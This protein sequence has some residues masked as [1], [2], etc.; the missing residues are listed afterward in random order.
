[1]LMDITFICCVRVHGKKRLKKWPRF[2]QSS[3]SEIML[4]RQ[5]RPFLQ[6]A[7][8]LSPCSKVCILSVSPRA[9]ITGPIPQ[10]GKVGSDSPTPR[11]PWIGHQEC[12]C[13]T[14]NSKQ[15]HSNSMPEHLGQ[16]VE[17]NVQMIRTVHVKI[18]FNVYS[19]P[20]KQEPT[21]KEWKELHKV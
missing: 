5:K 7:N 18:S 13:N 21:N 17:T 9:A 16:Q 8:T 2:L 14:T 1:M 15:D 19:V 11:I 12:W 10:T 4:Y 3:V 20:G 6:S